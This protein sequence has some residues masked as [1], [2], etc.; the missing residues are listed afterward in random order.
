M[1]SRNDATPRKMTGRTVASTSSSLQLAVDEPMGGLLD[2][3][4]APYPPYG[5]EDA[6][7]GGDDSEPSR[8]PGASRNIASLKVPSAWYA[9]AISS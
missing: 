7:D 8:A 1:L 6:I 2:R 9:E 4:W 3:P 5:S